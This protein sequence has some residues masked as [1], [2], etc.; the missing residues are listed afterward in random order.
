MGADLRVG[1]GKEVPG[2]RPSRSMGETFNYRR[3]GGGVLRVTWGI[4]RRWKLLLSLTREDLA[5]LVLTLRSLR[6]LRHG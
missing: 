5:M 3:L 2:P 4:K 6:C 1:Y